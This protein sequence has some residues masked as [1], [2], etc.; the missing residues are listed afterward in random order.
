MTPATQLGNLGHILFVSKEIKVWQW[1]GYDDT[2]FV[3]WFHHHDRERTTIFWVEEHN[4]H[5][6]H[7][8]PAHL[9][10]SKQ[11]WQSHSW[12]F[13]SPPVQLTESHWLN[14]WEHHIFHLSFWLGRRSSRA[15]RLEAR[16]LNESVMCDKDHVDSKLQSETQQLDVPCRLNAG[17]QTPIGL[18]WVNLLVGK[19]LLDIPFVW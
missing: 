1:L 4:Q 13:H 2:Q 5:M 10:C 9:I 16:D 3:G 19:L 8:L 12:L 15:E 18:Y 17:S 14:L 6:Y 11:T 7:P